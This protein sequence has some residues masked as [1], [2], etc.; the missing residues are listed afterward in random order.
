MRKSGFTL[1][2]LITAM[3]IIGIVVG[4]AVPKFIDF[5]EEALAAI[6]AQAIASIK[7]G[8]N[9]YYIE[10]I[11]SNREPVFPIL[12]DNAPGDSVACDS[13]P[14]FDVVL[15]QG[16]I[17]DSSWEKLTEITYQLPSSSIFKYN[18]ET[19]EFTLWGKGKKGRGKWKNK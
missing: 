10:S 7:I 1:I 16:G 8:I 6:E 19:G 11:K 3:L 4:I 17:R 14:F 13:N 18:P 2:E 5:R 15:T 12:L 9:N